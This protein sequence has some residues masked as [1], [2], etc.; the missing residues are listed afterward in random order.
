MKRNFESSHA[1]PYTFFSLLKKVIKAF[2]KRKLLAARLFERRTWQYMASQRNWLLIA[3]QFSTFQ[4]RFLTPKLLLHFM[5]KKS[6][7]HFTHLSNHTMQETDKL[8]TQNISP[9]LEGHLKN[10]K[11]FSA[12][13]MISY[14]FIS[15]SLSISHFFSSL[16]S[17][18]A[19]LFFLPPL[20]FLPSS[21]RNL[22][23]TLFPSF[24]Q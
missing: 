13:G 19:F 7:D 18:E 6:Y 1:F 3:F 14:Y 9:I 11:C 17:W 8:W 16:S 4:I 12:P 2:I 5:D 21:E 23:P 22:T 20:V 10:L 15:V 24:L